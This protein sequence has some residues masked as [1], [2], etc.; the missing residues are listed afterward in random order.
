MHIH[1]QTIIPKSKRYNGSGMYDYPVVYVDI[2]TT[3]GSARNSRVLEVAAI[4]V[5]PDGSVREFSSLLDP[6]TYIPSNITSIT[7]ITSSDIIGAPK[8]TDIADELADILSGAVFI[9]H[10]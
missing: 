9:A 3:G 5:E 2:E 8:F 7:G 6:E 10:N 4:R 1:I